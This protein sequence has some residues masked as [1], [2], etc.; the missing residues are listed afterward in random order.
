MRDRL[1]AFIGGDILVTI[2]FIHTEE[3]LRVMLLGFIGGFVGLAGKEFYHFLE[4][5]IKGK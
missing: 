3:I 5:K 2:N 4:R 1:L